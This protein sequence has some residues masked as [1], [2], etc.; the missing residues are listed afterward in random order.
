MM[1]MYDDRKTFGLYIKGVILFWSPFQLRPSAT[2]YDLAK[3][4][5]LEMSMFERLVKMGLP[6]VR[7]NY[8]VRI[9]VNIHFKSQQSVKGRR[10]L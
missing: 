8:Q 10:Y 1:M 3:N 9:S 4:F 5:D 6:Y 7:L 2:V